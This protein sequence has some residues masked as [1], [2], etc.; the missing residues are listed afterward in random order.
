MIAVP[1]IWGHPGRLG[2]ANPLTEKCAFSSA[3][4][5]HRMISTFQSAQGF[6]DKDMKNKPPWKPTN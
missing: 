1:H 2:V 5:E 3:G 6:R 4:Y